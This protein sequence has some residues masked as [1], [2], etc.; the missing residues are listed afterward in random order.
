MYG[1]VA[2]PHHRLDI[3]FEQKSMEC[4]HRSLIGQSYDGTGVLSGAK[5]TYPAVGNFT[6]KAMAGIDGVPSDYLVTSHQTDQV[7]RL[8]ELRRRVEA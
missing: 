3:S 1:H 8:C 7:L 4:P 6:T 2:G 5:D